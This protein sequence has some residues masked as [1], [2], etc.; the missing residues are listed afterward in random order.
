M[1]ISE[2]GIGLLEK[3]EKEEYGDR[4]VNVLVSAIQSDLYEKVEHLAVLVTEG[5]ILKDYEVDK[6]E[7]SLPEKGEPTTKVFGPYNPSE[8]GIRPGIYTHK[9]AKEIVEKLGIE[10]E[11]SQL[12][13]KI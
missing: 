13:I 1:G 3:L 11:L 9:K 8:V 12:G 2:E 4:R 6:V 7:K 5:P 10:S